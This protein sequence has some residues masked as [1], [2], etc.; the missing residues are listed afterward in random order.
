MRDRQQRF[1][2]F[3]LGC[4]R[5]LSDNVSGIR[6]ALHVV[7]FR[8]FD[9]AVEISARVVASHGIAQRPVLAATA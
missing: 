6:K 5:Q 7:G 4:L 1:G 2:F 8:H 3:Y 9:Q